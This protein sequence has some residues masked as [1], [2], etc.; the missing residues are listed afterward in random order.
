[1]GISR[2][3]CVSGRSNVG[4]KPG[5][6]FGVGESEAEG[7]SKSNCVSRLKESTGAGVGVS[8]F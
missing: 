7:K 2:S 4:S 8:L 5:N 3:N 6:W 1:V